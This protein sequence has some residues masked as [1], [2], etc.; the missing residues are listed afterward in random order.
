MDIICIYNLISPPKCREL[1]N[2]KIV[3]MSV[4]MLTPKSKQEQKIHTCKACLIRKV[5]LALVR[6]CAC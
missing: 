6:L 2:A 1:L 4:H 3:L 5:R